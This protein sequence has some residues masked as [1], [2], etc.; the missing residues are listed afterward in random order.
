MLAR[1]GHPL[2]DVPGWIDLNGV[3]DDGRDR[4]RVDIKPL[5]RRFGALGQSDSA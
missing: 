2:V 4:V 1:A 3:S 5:D